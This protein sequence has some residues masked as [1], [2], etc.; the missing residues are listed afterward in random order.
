MDSKIYF[1][2]ISFVVETIRERCATFRSLTA[3]VS[4]ISGG[5]TNV[6]PTY[7]SSIDS[8]SN[9]PEAFHRNISYSQAFFCAK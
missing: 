5:Q 3:T 4:E 7:F 8:Y 9:L 1:Q 2:I 6:G